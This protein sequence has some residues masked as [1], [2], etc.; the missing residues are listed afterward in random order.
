MLFLR[1]STTGGDAGS[2]L[3]RGNEKV[4]LAN[5]SALTT[6]ALGR[7]NAGLITV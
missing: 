3:V 4:S 2:I 5:N 6:E 1:A 7:G